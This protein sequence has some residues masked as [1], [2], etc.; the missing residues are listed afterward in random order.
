MKI[1]RFLVVFLLM[2]LP[3]NAV[4]EF[5]KYVDENG[6]VH[7]TEFLSEVPRDQLL[8]VNNY[9][10]EDDLLTEAER[11]EKASKLA[12]EKAEAQELARVEEEIRKTEVEEE[13]NIPVLSEMNQEKSALDQEFAK[14]MEEK[15]V[16]TYTRKNLKTT[17]E[18]EKYQADV[19]SLNSRIES[20]EARRK[21]F[22]EKADGFNA[23]IE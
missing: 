7:Y 14:L 9:L 3:C 17:E 8:K 6:F 20:Y 12:A 16:L 22:K 21:V 15:K 4:A 13:K 23:T 11:E 19:K 2:A 18:A 1:S 5:F 10:E